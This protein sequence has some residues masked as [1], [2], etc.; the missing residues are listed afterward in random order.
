MNKKERIKKY[1]EVFSPPNLVDDMLDKLPKAVWSNPKL[2]WLDNS[3]GT[4]I[5]LW[6]GLVPRLMAGLATK[7]PDED[8]R[9]AHIAGMIYGV[10]IQ[11]INVGITRSYL[12]KMLGSENLKTIKKQVV[13]HDSLTFDYWNDTKFDILVGNPPYNGGVDL[14]FLTLAIEKLDVKHLL[15][16]HPSTYLIDRKGNKK[17]N[18][19][20]NLLDGKLKSATLFNGNPVFNIGLFVPCM[21][22]DYDRDYSGKC[23]VEYFDDKFKADVYNITKFGKEWETIVKPFTALMEATCAA[24]NNIWE[25]RAAHRNENK[26]NFYCQLTAIRGNVC[27]G[28]NAEQNKIV[29]DS[30]YTMVMKDSDTNKGIRNKTVRK[31]GYVV[32]EFASAIEQNNFIEYIKSNFARFCLALLKNNA[33]SHYGEMALIPWMDFAQSWDDKKLFKH[34]GIDKETQEYIKNFL[35]EYYV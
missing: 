4:G 14:K 28:M 12:V 15:Y 17:F 19:I 8:A 13:C 31:D 26:K 3:C 24:K 10:D 23:A 29:K 11:L 33:N 5:F 16:V 6:H 27:T 1:G 9:K 21:I 25:K 7:F 22:I 2:K 34:F 35:P 32:H 20:K 30:F 18:T